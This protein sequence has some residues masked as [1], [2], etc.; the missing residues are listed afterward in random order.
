[1]SGPSVLLWYN[2]VPFD[3]Q[4]NDDKVCNYMWHQFPIYTEQGISSSVNNYNTTL[5]PTMYL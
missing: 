4:Y 3:L 1:M 5:W 2:V